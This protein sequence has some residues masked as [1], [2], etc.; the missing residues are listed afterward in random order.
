M[1]SRSRTIQIENS[2]P[3]KAYSGAQKNHN[4]SSSLSIDSDSGRDINERQRMDTKNESDHCKDR[5]ALRSGHAD[6]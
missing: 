5:T 1:K 6:I 2:I 3:G 4:G